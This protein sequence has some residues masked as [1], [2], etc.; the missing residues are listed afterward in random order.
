MAGKRKTRGGRSNDEMGEEVRK[1]QTKTEEC[2]NKF[3]QTKNK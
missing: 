3:E 1:R 2:A